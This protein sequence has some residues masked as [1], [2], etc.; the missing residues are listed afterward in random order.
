LSGN[1]GKKHYDQAIAAGMNSYLPKP[2]TKTELLDVITQF[3]ALAEV[4]TQPISPLPSSSSQSSNPQKLPSALPQFERFLDSDRDRR[5]TSA[6]NAQD[7][8]RLH[9]ENSIFHNCCF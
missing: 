3:T 7:V 5:R 9:Q 8:I 2:Y 1:V 6:A 4:E